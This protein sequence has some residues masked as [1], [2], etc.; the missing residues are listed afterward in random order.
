MSAH[1]VAIAAGLQRQLDELRSIIQLRSS[2]TP[3]PSV[4]AGTCE[5]QQCEIKKL[6]NRIKHLVRALDAK[7]RRIQELQTQLQNSSSSHSSRSSSN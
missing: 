7:D 4:E 1:E 2:A 3:V 5:Q 6:S